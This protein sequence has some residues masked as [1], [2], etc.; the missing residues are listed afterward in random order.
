[1]WSVK[2]DRSCVISGSYDKTVKV[3]FPPEMR[4][5]ERIVTI[6][7]PAAIVC[8][9]LLAWSLLARSTSLRYGGIMLYS[10]VAHGMRTSPVRP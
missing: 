7:Q 6:G 1:M 5:C 3:T 4:M 9:P 10:C 2:F 8:C